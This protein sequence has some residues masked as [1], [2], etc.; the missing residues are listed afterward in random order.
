MEVKK[1]SKISVDYEGTF[2]DGEVFDSSSHGDHSH[3]LEFEAGAGQVIAGFDNAVLGMKVGDEKTFRI[4]SKDAYGDHRVELVRQIPRD[5]LPKDQEPKEGM[6][7]IVGSPDGRQF[8]VKITKVENDKVSI[9]LNHPLA[10][11]ALNFKIKIVEI[12]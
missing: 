2:D 1:G 5:S 10:G 12:N 8:P 11:K 7:L 4:E 6:M 9:D 3:P